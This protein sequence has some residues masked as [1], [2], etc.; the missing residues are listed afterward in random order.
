[1]SLFFLVLLTNLGDGKINGEFVSWYATLELC[2]TAKKSIEHE[3]K[4]DGFEPLQPNQRFECVRT[5]G[6]V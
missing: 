5:V 3:H 2:A 1:M 4:A 6:T